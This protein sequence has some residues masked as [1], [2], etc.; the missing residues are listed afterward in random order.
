MA[1]NTGLQLSLELS[2]IL[3]IRSVVETVGTQ[4]LKLARDLRNSGS[5]MLVEEDLADIF[6]RGRVT[7]E[8]EA[9]FKD[10]VKI[11]SFVPL[12]QGCVINLESG[13]GPTMLRAFR[14]RRYFAMVI[15]LSLL[16]WTHNRQDL[17]TMLS[18]AMTE[19][20]EMGLPEA[21]PSPGFDGIMMTLAACSSQSSPFSW[22]HYTQLVEDRLR[23]FVSD[24]YHSAEY[25]KIT[26][27]LLMTAMD[28][29]YL[30]QRF[31]EDRKMTVSN[32]MGSITLI[33]WAHY[34]LGLNVVITNSSDMVVVFGN[35]QNPQVIITWVETTG[36]VFNAAG[37]PES[38]ELHENE[39]PEIRLL[40]SKMSV[41]LSSA[42]EPE[43][44][45][46]IDAEDRHLLANYGTTYLQRLYNT[47]VITD[48]CDPIYSESVS[49]VTAFA[50]YMDRGFDNKLNALDGPENGEHDIPFRPISVETWR[51][52]ASAKLI[53]ANT[54]PQPETID[55][56]LMRLGESTFMEVS[57][58]YLFAPYERVFDIHL[59]EWMLQHLLKSLAMIVLILR[60][61]PRLKA[62]RICLL[63][64]QSN[65][66]E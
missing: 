55:Y 64:S 31:P 10:V 4:I 6:G 30:V 26:S 66:I 3:P 52:L 42:P 8:L 29:L 16:G 39:G 22:S 33:V 35:N 47:T 37:W 13:P 60:M 65:R 25:I 44:W 28:Y 56:Y 51:I 19:R 61:W 48:H 34:I 27:A 5:D 57:H 14:D 24:Y 18:A 11:Q 20:A 7:L 1:F 54:P 9:K 45:N 21:S 46:K 23:T 58:Q 17:A 36:T 32:Q 62:A 12:S 40:D 41:V 63:Y 49:I 50:I 38:R 43:N 2:K 59:N 53:F 15:Q